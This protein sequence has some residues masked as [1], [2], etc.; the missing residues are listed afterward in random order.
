MVSVLARYW[1]WRERRIVR[2]RMEAFHLYADA[3]VIA[4]V[5]GL[6]DMLKSLP[7]REGDLTP[8]QLEAARMSWHFRMLEL[9]ETGVLADWE[10][11]LVSALSS[12]SD[13]PWPWDPPVPLAE[14]LDL[15]EEP[16]G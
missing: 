7:T 5:D 8:E 11:V 9:S 6:I 15:E 10:A 16:C 13:R 2:R 4:F 12:V 1:R 3:N 14:I